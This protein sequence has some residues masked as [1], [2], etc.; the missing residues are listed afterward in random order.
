MKRTNRIVYLLQEIAIIV[1]GVLIAFSVENY[2]EKLDNE[3]Y[4]RTT[5][6]AIENEIRLSQKEVDTVLERHLALYKKLESAIE[7]KG[8]SL[9]E[10]VS[11]AGGVQA[12]AV[13]NISLRFF[14]S[15]KAELLDFQIISQ[16]LDIEFQ[17]KLLSQKMDRFADFAIDQINSKDPDTKIKFAYLLGD[18]IDGEQTLLESYTNFLDKNR[19]YLEN[20]SK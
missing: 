20:R 12:A 9:G 5:L 11:G 3:R 17:T 4:I 10:F 13:K 2:K 15:S 6:S 16:L 8:E 1:F 18:V 7:E 19:N 14:V